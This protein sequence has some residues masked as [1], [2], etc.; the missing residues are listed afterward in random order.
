MGAC[1]RVC[2]RACM[3]SCVR[4]CMRAC[5]CVCVCACG[6]VC[7]RVRAGVC[8]TLDI[9]DIQLTEAYKRAVQSKGEVTFP[10]VRCMLC[11]QGRVGK[12]SLLATLLEE[13]FVANRV[14]TLCLDLAM[15]WCCVGRSGA[16]KR[17]DDSK[18]AQHMKE[19]LA[20]QSMDPADSTVS[21]DESGSEEPASSPVE[22]SGLSTA[23]PSA[24]GTTLPS[25]GSSASPLD[26][27]SS[28]IADVVQLVLS[29][30]FSEHPFEQL[31]TESF[32]AL[33]AWDLAGQESY[34]CIHSMVC[35]HLRAV[36]LIV[37][38]AMDPIVEKAAPSTYNR[39]GVEK[40]IGQAL[41]K[42]TS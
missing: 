4:V 24:P 17:L 42:Q 34:R 25:S 13:D 39:S 9:T 18:R 21:S 31:A 6:C 36:Y 14:S 19:L 3:R 8:I 26:P 2:V 23:S 40:P 27:M 35:P 28:A 37:Y 5:E 12:S 22:E 33:H 38:N 29:H 10:C 20:R 11:G 32:A 41:A 16:W 30:G 1:V 15:V 7:M